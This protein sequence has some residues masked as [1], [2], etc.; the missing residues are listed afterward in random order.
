MD[1]QLNKIVQESDHFSI[2]PNLS[3]KDDDKVI[4]KSEM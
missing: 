4:A 1:K 2:Q 3:L